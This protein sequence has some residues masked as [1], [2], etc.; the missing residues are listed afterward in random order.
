MG[1]QSHNKFTIS[2]SRQWQ[3]RSS[4]KNC[5]KHAEESD[6]RQPGYE[7]SDTAWLNTPTE[8]GHYSPKL[9]SRRMYTQLSMASELLKSEIPKGVEDIDEKNSM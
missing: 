1:I 8:G 6:L 2:Q 4:S 9:Q 7:P 3:G 5:K